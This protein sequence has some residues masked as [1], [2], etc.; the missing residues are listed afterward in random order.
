MFVCVS[1][2]LYLCVYMCYVCVCVCVCV[3]SQKSPVA[4]SLMKRIFQLVRV[5]FNMSEAD[6]VQLV[7]Y[8][9]GQVC[10]SFTVMC[11]FDLHLC[12]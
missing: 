11:P 1:V 4:V 7:R 8:K 5:S 12:L 6:G 3:I 9:N 10:A 2:S